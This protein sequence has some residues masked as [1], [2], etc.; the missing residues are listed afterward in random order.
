MGSPGWPR[1]ASPGGSQTILLV[2][3]EEDG[4]GLAR[5]VLQ[6]AG[7]R[8]LEAE[9]AAEALRVSSEHVGAIHLLVSDVVMP[10]MGG[11]ELA[12]RLTASRPDLRILY[13]SGYTGTR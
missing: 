11:V 9:S 4:R 13:I 3:D 8:V 7:Y 5:D 10:E 2:E 12:Q 6:D 1:S